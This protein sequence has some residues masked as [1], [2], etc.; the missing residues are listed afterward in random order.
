[1]END[2]DEDEDEEEKRPGTETTKF[3]TILKM[4]DLTNSLVAKPIMKLN[5]S[6]NKW[7][8]RILVAN[9]DYIGYISKVPEGYENNT[10]PEKAVPKM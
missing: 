4:P 5:N 6:G 8:R 2:S 3:A 1:M 7:N 10:I 9:N